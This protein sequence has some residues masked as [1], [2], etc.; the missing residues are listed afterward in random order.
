MDLQICDNIAMLKL[1]WNLSGKK[2]NLW[3][4]WIN[5]YYTKG[6]PILQ[7]EEKMS[8]SWIFK[9]ILKQKDV[10]VG[11]Q[12]WNTMQRF[13][14]RHIYKYQRANDELVPWFRIFCGN[15]ARPRALF[16][17][18]LACHGNLAT[19]S[20][21]MR[22][23]MVHYAKCCYCDQ[24]ETIYHILFDCQATRMNWEQF[25]EWIGICHQPKPWSE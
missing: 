2:D 1:L 11:L 20:R 18:W 23:G 9:A 24:E 22:F 14:T 13:M 7:V 17:L 25:L 3:V 15:Y 4:R 10:V 8:Q 12:D 5:S 16:T 6:T 19:R 21:L